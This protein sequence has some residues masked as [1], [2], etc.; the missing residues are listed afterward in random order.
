MATT[1]SEYKQTNS[2]GLNW[3]WLKLT[4]GAADTSVVYVIAGFP[5]LKALTMPIKTTG[6][7]GAVSADYAMATGT[8]TI[9]CGNSDVIRVGYAQ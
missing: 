7:V 1:V 2:H 6:T 8:L 9:A 3:T 4:A 5:E